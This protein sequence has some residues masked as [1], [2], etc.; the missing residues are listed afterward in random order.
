[1]ILHR[2]R[3][4]PIGYNVEHTGRQLVVHEFRHV[5]VQFRVLVFP[6]E[7][8]RVQFRGIVVVVI[9]VGSQ[10]P[11]GDDFL[12]GKLFHETAIFHWNDYRCQSID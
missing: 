3:V 9:V 6:S 12:A 10:F 1:M 5:R 7:Q 8:F 2:D 11:T 4:L